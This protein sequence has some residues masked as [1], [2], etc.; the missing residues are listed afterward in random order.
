MLTISIIYGKTET[1]SGLLK[2]V[3][4]PASHMSAKDLPMLTIEAEWRIYAS[5]N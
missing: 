4:I 1:V 2:M 3:G 5:V